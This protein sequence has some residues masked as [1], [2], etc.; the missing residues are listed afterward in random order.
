[1]DRFGV[2]GAAVPA[3]SLYSGEASFR[4]GQAGS[5]ADEIDWDGWGWDDP[6]SESGATARPQIAIAEAAAVQVAAA[7]ADFGRTTESAA[8]LPDI[9]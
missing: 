9:P 6:L 5:A 7:N 2:R 8:A 3:A 1:M 4:R